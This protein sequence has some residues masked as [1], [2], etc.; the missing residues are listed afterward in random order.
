MAW[1]EFRPVASG[2]AD[3]HLRRDGG[4]ENTRVQSQRRK[5]TSAHVRCVVSPDPSANTN[6]ATAAI[7]S[8]SPTVNLKNGLNLN[9][10]FEVLPL[11]CGARCLAACHEQAG[12]SYLR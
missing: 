8:T 9:Q 6:A 4:E 7:V 1:S 11:A 2:Q 5:G 3:L 12:D 10:F